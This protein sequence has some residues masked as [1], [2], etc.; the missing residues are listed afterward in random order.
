[1]IVHDSQEIRVKNG[2]KSKIQETR[3]DALGSN[4]GSENGGPTS[5]KTGIEATQ[6]GKRYVPSFEGL[7]TLQYKRIRVI[8][9]ARAN[10]CRKGQYSERREQIVGLANS[11]GDSP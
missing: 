7:A 3:Y 9:A 1:M 8:H 6:P 10:R 11:K 2:K 4:I 5:Q